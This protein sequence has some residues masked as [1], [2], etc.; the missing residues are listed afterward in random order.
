MR[1]FF[2]LILAVFLFVIWMASWLVYHIAGGLIHVLLVVAVISLVL[3]F[4]RKSS[5]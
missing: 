1:D 5:A 2:F 3:H 4:F